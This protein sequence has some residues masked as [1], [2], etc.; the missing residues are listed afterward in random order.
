MICTLEPQI[1]NADLVEIG[2]TV[3]MGI[4]LWCQHPTASGMLSN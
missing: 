3:Q 1:Q 2:F 4:V